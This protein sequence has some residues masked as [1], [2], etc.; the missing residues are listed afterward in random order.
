MAG[1]LDVC[2]NTDGGFQ[3][4]CRDG[5]VIDTDNKTCINE[6]TSTLLPKGLWGLVG[7]LCFLV[8]VA[9]V[10]I[11]FLG[12]KQ[13]KG[14]NVQR[15]ENE[16]THS[17]EGIPMLDIT[18]DTTTQLRNQQISTRQLDGRTSSQ[19]ED[20]VV[21]NETYMKE[22][23]IDRNWEIPRERLKITEDKLGEGEFGV[24]KK[25]IY[26]R[27][28][29]TEL[30]VAVKM[31]KGFKKLCITQ[32]RNVFSIWGGG[33]GDAKSSRADFKFIFSNL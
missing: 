23:G 33:R 6:S 16:M 2:V 31:L 11:V 13:K 17:Q 28:D 12:M 9:F 15:D 30:P 25:G 26:L 20:E 27:R 7:A 18:T 14:R 4:K 10:V 24:I 19:I 22:M 21:D 3:C 5:Y 32:E 1:V 8:F 29:G